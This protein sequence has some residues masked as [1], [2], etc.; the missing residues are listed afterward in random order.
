VITISA[1]IPTRNRYASL[2]RT[3]RSLASQTELPDEVIIVDSSDI[4][5]NENALTASFPSLRITYMRSRASVCVQRN[6]G[7][8]KASGSHIF[9]CDDDLE[10]PSHYVSTIKSMIGTDPSLNILT[11][12]C[13]ER[14]KDG[15]WEYEYPLKSIG[16][17]CW[18]FFFQQSIWCNV[19]KLRVGTFTRFFLRPV[20]LFYSRKKNT[21]SLAG[22]PL[23]THFEQPMYK[24]AFYGLGASVIKK[25]WLLSNPFDESLGPHGIGDHYGL[26]L[27]FPEFP[28]IH[29]ITDLPAYHH[30]EKDNRLSEADAFYQ[31]GL[32]L[33]YFLRSNAKFKLVNRIFF[34]WSLMGHWIAFFLKGNLSYCRS[35]NRLILNV[36]VGRNPYLRGGE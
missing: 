29:V 10:F 27:H 14:N 1:I 19:N 11:G 23:V 18:R 35:I 26:A 28:A 3:L 17:L 24:T 22:W 13:N 21:Y 32:A 36:V 9:L 6:A 20:F 12:S 5:L 8:Q 4:P 2:L 33:H 30:K 34:I 7:I 16:Q 15:N 25:D 31:R